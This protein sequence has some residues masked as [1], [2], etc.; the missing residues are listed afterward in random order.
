MNTDIRPFRIDIPQEDL[1]DLRARLGRTRWPRPLPGDQWRR[2]VPV[3]YL[4]ELVEYW[5][6]GYDWRA[7]EARLNGFPQHTTEIDGH[8]V[9][10][11]H[12]R[13][14]APDAVPLILTH[15]WPNSFVEFADLIGPLSKD[16]HVVVPSLPGFGFS[17]PPSGTGWDTARVARMWA[18][19]MDRLGYS[20]YGTQGGDFGA[21]VAPEIARIAPEHVI[22]VYLISGLGFPTEAD[23]P[24]L[25]EA[26]RET[27]TALMSADWAN[28]V[29]HHA[30]LRAAPQTFAYGWHDS[31]AGALAWMVQ[32]FKEFNASGKP[33]EEV[34][35]RDQ[36]LTNTSVYWFTG[37][38]GSSAWPYYD[39][40]GF[41]WP[42]G[43]PGV[44]TGVYSG[45]PGIR[46]LA[47]RHTRVVHWAE[48]NPGGH[49]FTAMDQPDHLAADIR[50]FFGAV[51]REGSGW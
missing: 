10:F 27:Y 16:F 11:L 9:H 33:L 13:S 15:G 23:L 36:I 42:Q 14:T 17:A 28:G 7:H 44:P 30:L 29:D 5:R 46:R 47:E 20:R 35:S 18:E 37:T 31:P 21:Y 45:P 24:E 39:S 41:A 50:E 19:L 40:S 43:V 38:F 32:K 2:G 22:G 34:I 3:D 12:V 8:E 6:D 51:S 1:D 49:H 4:R 25:T 26:E 48:D